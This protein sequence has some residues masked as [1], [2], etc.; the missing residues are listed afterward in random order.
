MFIKLHWGSVE[1]TL[2]S[3]ASL[4]TKYLR[5]LVNWTCRTDMTKSSP[6]DLAPMVSNVAGQHVQLTSEKQQVIISVY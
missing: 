4:A 5:T 1:L 3:K 2:Q 6:Q